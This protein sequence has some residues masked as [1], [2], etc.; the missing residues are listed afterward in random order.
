VTARSGAR[1][2]R[3]SAQAELDALLRRTLAEDRVDDDRTTRALFPRPVPARAVVLAERS[4][5]LSGTAAVRRLAIL[6][7]LRVRRCRRDGSRLAPG[8]RVLELTGDL[9]TILGVER[10]LLNLLMHLSGVATAADEAVR[11]ARGRLAVLG[12]RKTIPG[13]RHLEK[14]ALRHGGAGPHRADLAQAILVKNNHLAHLDLAEALR[15]I[16][17]AYGPRVPVE[18]EVGREREALAALASGVGHLLI[19]NASPTRARAIVAAVRAAPGGR[20]ARIEL[21]GG[22]TRANLGRYAATGA[23]AASLGELTHSARALPFHLRV[24]ATRRS[25]RAR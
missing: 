7:G 23:D 5:V 2:P 8:E 24:R 17:A 19:D 10:A 4:G 18:V 6:T 20:R 9:R 21:S 22:I 14:A 3:R 25:V 13:L 12:T 11:R 16:R 15:R 1:P